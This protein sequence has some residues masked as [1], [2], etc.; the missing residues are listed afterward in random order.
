M[1]RIAK[2]RDSSRFVF[3]RISCGIFQAGSDLK[4]R[5]NPWLKKS[6]KYGVRNENAVLVLSI[7]LLYINPSGS[8]EVNSLL[9]FI[10]QYF[11]VLK[12]LLT[13]YTKNDEIQ[14]DLPKGKMEYGEYVI[15]CAV[16]EVN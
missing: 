14:L 12:I 13:G 10:C 6:G 8:I 7:I 11:I 5:S 9:T 3:Y 4:V 15:Y 1:E 16:R 2:V